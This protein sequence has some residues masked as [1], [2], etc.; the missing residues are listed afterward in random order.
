M[1]LKKFVF[2]TFLSFQDVRLSSP[3]SKLVPRNETVKIYKLFFSF[4]LTLILTNQCNHT[5]IIS[6][7]SIKYVSSIHYFNY[8]KTSLT[9]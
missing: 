1:K 8:I 4:Y 5:S 6:I 9:I 7:F 3:Y 2:L